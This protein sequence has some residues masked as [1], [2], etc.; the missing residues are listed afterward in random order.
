MSSCLCPGIMGSVDAA[1]TEAWAQQSSGKSTFRM[2][3]SRNQRSV[4]VVVRADLFNK[5]DRPPCLNTVGMHRGYAIGA[6]L[7][8]REKAPLPSR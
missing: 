3:V 2:F 6:L 1:L 7:A 8:L 4:L 5:C